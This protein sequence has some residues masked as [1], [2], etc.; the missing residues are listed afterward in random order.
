MYGFDVKIID[1]MDFPASTVVKNP[2]ANA[3]D[4]DSIPGS[5]RFHRATKPMRHNYWAH[6]LQSPCSA[7]GTT[8]R[9]HHNK[10][11]TSHN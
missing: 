6:I 10:K 9:S 1:L 11:L 8:M 3:G 2:P 5:E 4:M 7:I